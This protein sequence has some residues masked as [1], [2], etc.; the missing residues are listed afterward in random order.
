[1]KNNKTGGIDYQD[2]ES[3]GRAKKADLLT[4]PKKVDGT[5]CGNCKF[6][7]ILHEEKGEGFCTHKD[8]RLPVTS[9]MCCA[10]WNADGSSRSWEK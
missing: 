6:V 3:L 7:K 1:M 10:L 9:R 5:N 8:V 4:L 2:K